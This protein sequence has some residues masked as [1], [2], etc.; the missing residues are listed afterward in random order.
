MTSWHYERQGHRVGP[1]P[2]SEIQT[3]IETS[4]LHTDTL[5]WSPGLPDWVPLVDSPLAVYLWQMS[6]PPTLPSHTI[7]NVVVWFLAFAPIL[8]LMLQ[9][10]VAGM[11]ASN[12]Y[13]AEAE[14]TQALQSGRFWYLTLVLNIGLSLLDLKRL[15]AA[16]V[17][18]RTYGRV[19][20]LVPVY[21]W[22]RARSLHQQPITFWVWSAAFVLS[23]LATL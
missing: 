20:F 14:A 18:T 19:V 21:L 22:K 5:V 23:L 12:A 6:T 8:G 3:L 17:N 7:S 2:E 10:F 15:K 11:L 13:S 9:S 1:I 4:V 16:G